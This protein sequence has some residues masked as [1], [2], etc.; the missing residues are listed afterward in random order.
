MSDRPVGPSQVT[1]VVRRIGPLAT[2]ATH[3]VA[4]RA[5]LVAPYFIR[6]REPIV[7][8][9]YATTSIASDDLVGVA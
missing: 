3:Q 5:R 6:L 7:V 9:T 1:A 8:D 4:L 2:D